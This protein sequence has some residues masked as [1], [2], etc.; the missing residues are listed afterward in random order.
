LKARQLNLQF[1]IMTARSLSEDFKN[2]QCAVIDGQAQM[3][4]K[5]A[6]LSGA[7]RLIKQNLLGAHLFCHEFNFIGFARAHKQGGIWGLAFASHFGHRLEACRQGQLTEFIQLCIKM[8]Q[9][10]I[11]TH[12][13]GRRCVNQI[14]AQNS[15]L[16]S[17][18][19]D[20]F[21]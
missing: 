10:K 12:Q 19:V 14:A 5:V 8:R 2:E 4:F 11:N 13:Q 15:E 20:G 18:L 16:S 1:A 9:A 3:A 6:L 21:V 17:G 7:Q